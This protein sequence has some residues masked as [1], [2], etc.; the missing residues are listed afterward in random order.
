MTALDFQVKHRPALA[1]FLASDLGQDLMVVLHNLRMKPSF[2]G[3]ESSA[4]Y[5]LGSINGYEQCE[6]N[7]I[8]LSLVPKTLTPQPVQNYGVTDKPV[9]PEKPPA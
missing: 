7:I 9:E 4:G 2:G 3:S 5:V 1:E 6:Q 8:A